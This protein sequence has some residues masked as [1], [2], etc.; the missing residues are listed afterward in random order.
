MAGVWSQEHDV[1]LTTK[2]VPLFS[3]MVMN[4]LCPGLKLRGLLLGPSLVFHS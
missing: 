2:N 4:S 3:V 1:G